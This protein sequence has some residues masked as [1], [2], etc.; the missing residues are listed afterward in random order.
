MTNAR[1][2]GTYRG[3]QAETVRAVGRVRSKRVKKTVLGKFF[4]RGG[5]G[6]K[7]SALP[8][9]G[10]RV[11]TL[12]EKTL[13]TKSGRLS[14]NKRQ[15]RVL[16]LTRRR[17]KKSSGIVVRSGTFMQGERDHRGYPK[18]CPKQGHPRK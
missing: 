11:A 16:V 2:M 14:G 15:K 7:K 5:K 13:S 8:G 3:T 6:S 4:N 18:S 1:K 12:R 10:A 9:R 17:P